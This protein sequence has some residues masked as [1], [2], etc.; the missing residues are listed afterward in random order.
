[1]IWRR[2]ENFQKENF[3]PFV[4]VVARQAEKIQN[5][6][7]VVLKFRKS[8]KV[9]GNQMKRIR[10]QTKRVHHVKKHRQ[11]RKDQPI[12]TQR[13]QVD[14]SE[15]DKTGKKIQ[16]DVLEALLCLNT[17]CSEPGRRNY[18]SNSEI[19]NQKTRDMSLVQYRKNKKHNKRGVRTLKI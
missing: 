2:N 5:E 6:E 16:Q 3:D 17:K 19:S 4:R 10:Y 9:E 14:N 13:V 12:V 1:M 8:R 11:D 18:T 7:R 15:S